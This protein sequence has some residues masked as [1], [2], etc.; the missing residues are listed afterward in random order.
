[1]GKSESFDFHNIENS[2]SMNDVSR[3]KKSGCYVSTATGFVL[4]L[5]AAC[6][7]VGVGII[8][9][10]TTSGTTIDCK[11]SYPPNSGGNSDGQV[12]ATT[13]SPQKPILDQCKDLINSGSQ[14]LCK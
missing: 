6:L 10:F 8:V 4:T 13:P 14:E 2:S 5:L 3:Q 11:C 1:M 12:G 7:A 9:H